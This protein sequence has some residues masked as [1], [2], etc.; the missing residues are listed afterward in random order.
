MLPFYFYTEFLIMTCSFL[1]L[2]IIFLRF[3]NLLP[4]WFFLNKNH[5]KFNDKNL[6]LII[7]I[8]FGI[9]LSLQ[10][11]IGPVR[12][13]DGIYISKG[14]EKRIKHLISKEAAIARAFTRAD[15][16][17]E[18]KKAKYDYSTLIKIAKTENP[19]DKAIQEDRIGNLPLNPLYR[20]EIAVD[21]GLEGTMSSSPESSFYNE[22]RNG[23]EDTTNYAIQ[24]I[25]HENNK[26][27]LIQTQSE[28]IRSK[29]S[30]KEMG[31]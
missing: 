12:F 29:T 5:L 3:K 18:R 17:S 1:F 21:Y 16:S 23:L 30:L 28:S 20:S 13:S 27:N 14:Q 9:T 31:I 24:A 19:Y 8:I 2:I 11:L 10:L 15:G 6:T 22:A 4:S 26:I 25:L 7:A